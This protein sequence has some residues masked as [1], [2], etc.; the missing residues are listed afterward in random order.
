MTLRDANTH[1][2]SQ[3][4]FTQLTLLRISGLPGCLLIYLSNLLGLY[5]TVTKILIHFRLKNVRKNMSV[6]GYAVNF[7]YTC[8]LLLFLPPVHGKIG[9]ARKIWRERPKLA[10]GAANP[11]RG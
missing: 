6:Q 7:V 8:R 2:A 9:F 4:L 11:N 5:H 10:F 1:V 3:F